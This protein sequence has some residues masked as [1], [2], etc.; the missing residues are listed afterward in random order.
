MVI[1]RL[2]LNGSS[3][4]FSEQVKLCS[5]TSN[6]SSTISSMMSKRQHVKPPVQ[7]CSQNLSQSNTSIEDNNIATFLVQDNIIINII[8][9][10]DNEVVKTSWTSCSRTTSQTWSI[11][12]TTRQ[13]SPPRCRAC[14]PTATCRPMPSTPSS[15]QII[16]GWSWWWWK[17]QCLIG[18]D[19]DDVDGNAINGLDS[20]PFCTTITSARHL[21][22]WWWWGL[23]W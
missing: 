23:H 13:R 21:W 6:I 4:I 2:G 7:N 5:S 11:S 14:W 16:S 20:A 15:S 17:W 1:C 10:Q 19:H 9:L 18:R 3:P 8:F 12:R 22:C